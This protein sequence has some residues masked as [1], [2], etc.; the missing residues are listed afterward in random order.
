VNVVFIQQVPASGGSGG[1][2]CDMD[3]VL[4][5]V[6][7]SNGTGTWSKFAG[8][9]NAVFTPDNH[10]INAKV[11]V[12]KFGAYDFAWTVVNST[13]SS[14]DVV[15]VVFHDLPLVNAGRD[16]TI[17]KGKSVQLE[18]RGT[19]TVSWTP[20]TRLSNP[21]IINPSANPE[22]T[23]TYT[24]NLTDQFGCKNSDAIVIEVRNPILADAGPD[25]Q[26]GYVLNT[27]MNATLAHDYEKGLWSIISGTGDLTDNTNPKTPVDN[28]SIGENQFLWT[29][30]NGYCPVSQDTTNI[31]VNDF[32]I[33]TMITPNMDG[34]NDYF[35]LRG[36]T[37]LGKSELIIFDR[38]GVQVFK[39]S[40]YD[41]LWDGVDYNNK[42]LPEDTY[43]YVLKTANGKSFSGYLLIRR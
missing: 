1:N 19:G 39:N 17:C 40:D 28:L 24:V 36:L 8:P 35:E 18:A 33:P 42:P 21:N 23:T 10:T 12:D 6:L 11:T 41:N 43:Y 3:F 30:S 22:A 27:T 15:R 32:V 9:G 38:R 5:A 20:A 37:T 4:G 25:Q 26:L 7:P 14:S 29:V 2:E 31:V 13:C 34:R 16:T